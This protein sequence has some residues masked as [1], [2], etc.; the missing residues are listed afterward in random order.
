M[1][2]FHTI[3]GNSDVISTGSTA[4][5]STQSS[6]AQKAAD[7]IERFFK[8]DKNNDYFISAS[9][10]EGNMTEEERL[11]ANKLLE[12]RRAAHNKQL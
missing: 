11:E 3:N 8:F 1:V 5:G 6:D 9:E 2:D 10:A 7:G 12:E 4:Q